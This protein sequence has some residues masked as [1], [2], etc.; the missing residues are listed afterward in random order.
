MF[1]VVA[2]CKPCL[3]RFSTLFFAGFGAA[4]RWVIWIS[5]CAGKQVS[6]ASVGVPRQSSH[7]TLTHKP[8]K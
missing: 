1:K 7:L 2:A 8:L 4:G 6:L 5:W 3:A